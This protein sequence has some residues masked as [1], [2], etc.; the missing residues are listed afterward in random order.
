MVGLVGGV[1]GVYEN[2]FLPPSLSPF[3]RNIVSTKPSG[4]RRYLRYSFF[5]E[6]IRFQ[7]R[8]I[9]YHVDNRRPGYDY[10]L[11]T[12]FPVFSVKF[13]CRC[14]N[15]VQFLIVHGPVDFF[16]LKIIPVRKCHN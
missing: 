1:S 4:T 3:N 10:D 8:R 14:R 11:K 16:A 5:G 9:I 7:M 6:N 15:F 2:L 13:H 12:C